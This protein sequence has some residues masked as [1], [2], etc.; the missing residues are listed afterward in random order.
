M[1]MENLRQFQQQLAGSTAI[2]DFLELHPDVK[3]V[4]R[5]LWEWLIAAMGSKHAD[6]WIGEQRAEMLF[7]YEQIGSFV[8]QVYVIYQQAEYLD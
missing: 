2:I 7:F 5:I 8:E 3:D 4:K 6:M 1:C